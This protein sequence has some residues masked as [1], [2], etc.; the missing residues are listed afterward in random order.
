MSAAQK[1]QIAI[2]EIIEM[3]VKE[4]Q[5][6]DADVM[7]ALR[8]CQCCEEGALGIRMAQGAMAQGRVPN[9]K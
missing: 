6:T 2:Q 4:Y 5:L 1:L 7:G 3:H 9:K 8:V